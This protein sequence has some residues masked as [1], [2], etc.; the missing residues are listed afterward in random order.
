MCSIGEGSTLTGIPASTLRYYEKI[1]LLP[2][3]QRQNGKKNG[4]RRYDD[5]DL[6]HS[7]CLKE[8]AFGGA[9]DA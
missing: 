7:D 5:Q 1:S 4:I 2:N 6:R 8:Q 9:Y 3:P